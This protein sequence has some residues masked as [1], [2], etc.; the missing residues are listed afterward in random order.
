[1]AN[2]DPTVGELAILITELDRRV[3]QKFT[4]NQTAL[5]AALASTDKRLEQM[6]EFR[7]QLT[8][9]ERTFA[10][11]DVVS[12]RIDS[13]EAR[14]SAV[15][16]AQASGTGRDSG[17]SATK[18]NAMVVYGLVLA[19]AAIAVTLILTLMS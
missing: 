11:Q 16:V 6:N 3:Y 15:E 10:R 12:A 2:E 13:L 1:M 17:Q 5:A 14:L 19:A 8:D 9:R 7:G 4:D 18:S